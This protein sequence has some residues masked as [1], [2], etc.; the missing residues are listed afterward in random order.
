MP[1]R[2]T[3][4]APLPARLGPIC[5]VRRGRPRRR[6][7]PGRPRRPALVRPPSAPVCPDAGGTNPA[8]ASL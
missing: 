8:T 1:P 4:P 2:T 5:S 7:G 6:T 3:A